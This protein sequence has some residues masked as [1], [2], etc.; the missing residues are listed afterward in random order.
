MIAALNIGV[1]SERTPLK[2][3]YGQFFAKLQTL[4]DELQQQ[5]I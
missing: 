3:M 1:H 2:A 5:L 4:A